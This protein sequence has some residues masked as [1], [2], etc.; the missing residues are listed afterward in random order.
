MIRK[1]VLFFVLIMCLCFRVAYVNG[2]NDSYVV[3]V[4]SHSTPVVDGKLAPDEWSNVSTVLFNFTLAYL[5]HDASYLYVA[6]NV[7]DTTLELDKE[8]VYVCLDGSNDGGSS[9]NSSDDIGIGTF[10]NGTA[11]EYNLTDFVPRS[12]GW[13]VSTFEEAWGYTVEFN[14]TFA[15]IGLVPGENKTIGLLLNDYD[16]NVSQNYFW[17]L[18]GLGSDFF[19]PSNWGDMIIEPQS[20]PIYIRADGSIDPPNASISRNGNYYTLDGSIIS[21]TDGIVIERDN[22]ALDGEGYTLQGTG[23]GN[24]M[25]LSHR[26]N[27][28]IRN[29]IIR[30]FFD[31]ILLSYSGTSGILGNS[32]TANNNNGI[33][34]NS[35]PNNNI[36]GNNI[37]SN[38]ANGVYS[39]NSWN[40]SIYEDCITANIGH[41]VYFSESSYCSIFENNVTN[42][43]HG[44]SLDDSSNN[45]EISENH[46]ASQLYFGV[47]LSGVSFNIVSGNSLANNSVGVFLSES[48][49]FNTIVGNSMIGNTGHG[50]YLDWS[51]NNTVSRNSITNNLHGVGVSNSSTDNSINGNNITASSYFAIYFNNSQFNTVSGNNIASNGNGVCLYSFSDFNTVVGNNMTANTGH[52]VYLDGSSNNSIFGNSLTSNMHGIGVSN[53]STDNSIN[54]NNIT[55]SSYFAI[56]FNNSSGNSVCHNNIIGNTVQVYGD[57]FNVWD[58]GYPSGGNYWSDYQTRYPSASEIDTSGIWNTSYVID[59]NNTDHYPLMNPVPAI[60]EFSSFLV[61]PAF[62]LATL[63]ALVIWKRKPLKLSRR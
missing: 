6:F 20:G 24:G 36:N 33:M 58:D 39:Q 13:N 55:A 30:G 23:N 37:T 3:H 43:M 42:N 60:P 40:N 44:I 56:Y 15:R 11:F 51:S 19:L 62:M 14:I 8:G 38:K 22:I 61:L 53:S 29:M 35:S 18:G 57:S 52:G 16:A 21:G 50:V 49:S 59:T 1:R 12:L 34:I 26:N 5:M 47:A 17:P 4:F 48:S 32:I 9:F 27:V 25:I 7:S 63:V 46:L 28:T 31:G 10:R 45:N 41:G 54:G 2:H